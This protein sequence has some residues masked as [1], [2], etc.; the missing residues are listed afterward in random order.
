MKDNTVFN[1][2][3]NKHSA[4]SEAICDNQFEFVH[5]L[6]RFGI[7]CFYKTDAIENLVKLYQ[8][9][10]MFLT[11]SSEIPVIKREIVYPVKEPMEYPTRERLT[12]SSI[13]K[14]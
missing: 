14:D 2:E 12:E 3:E 4:K 6:I 8:F 13:L 5:R 11:Q 10:K 1:I 7:S 9:K